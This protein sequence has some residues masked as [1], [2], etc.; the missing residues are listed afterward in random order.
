MNEPE[1]S[2]NLVTLSQ[3]SVRRYTVLREHLHIVLSED[4]PKCTKC[5]SQRYI[6]RRRV[7]ENILGRVK[8][9]SRKATFEHLRLTISRMLA[10]ELASLRNESE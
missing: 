2:A 4:A 9:A 3:V 7:D 1:G 8:L 5:P 10:C 6:L